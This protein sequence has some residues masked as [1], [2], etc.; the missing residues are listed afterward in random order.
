MVTATYDGSV[1]TL[2]VD[3]QAVGA[4]GMTPALDATGGVT[5]GQAYLGQAYIGE[6]DEFVGYPATLNG[7]VIS[8]HWTGADEGRARAS[9]ALTAL[10]SGSEQ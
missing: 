10:R 9:N 8:R 3:A 1:L 4:T 6:Y 5:L 7:D 2:Y